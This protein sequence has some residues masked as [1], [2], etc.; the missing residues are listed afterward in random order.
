MIETNQNNMLGFGCMRLPTRDGVPMSENID[1]EEFAKMANYFMEAGFTYF[2]TSM[3]Y[4]QGKSENAVKEA[5]VERHPRDSFQVATKFP[6][7]SVKTEDQ[8]DEFF[9]QQLKNLGVDYV[10][11]YLL[12]IL[13]T[14]Y[15]DGFDMKGG[16]VESC[17]L[18]E[19]LKKFKEQ[20]QARH[21]GFSFHDSAD[22]LDKLLTEHPFVEFVQIV[23]NYYDWDSYLIQ[24]KENYEV[25]RKHG[26]AIIAME[27]V[28]GGMLSNVPKE[29]L[30][31]MHKFDK[32]ATPS[33]W[34][35]R[36]AASQPGVFKVLSGMSN[37]QQVKDNVSYMKDFKPLTEEETE[38]L[39]E[40]ARIMR[41][42]GPLKEYD[43]SKYESLTYHG[44]PVSAILQ[45]Y[46]S[47][48]S[49][50]TPSFGADNNYIR[51]E[52]IKNGV[53]DLHAALPDE[54]VIFE[55]KDITPTVKEAWDY[56]IKT[57]F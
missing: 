56:L 9:A 7:F 43:Y 46:N 13:M 5:V 14:Q 18:F 17:H 48:A 37:M 42:A 35:V 33:S 36:F 45:T 24:S 29:A 41:K 51:Q 55:G 12:H 54:T 25:L 38:M 26:K 27:P 28:K 49:S 32:D 31:L 50:P 21:V 2:D 53:S 34:A 11:F 47:I 16:V 1:I 15:I 23:I 39:F 52:L 19:H 20:G 3:A 22:V 40:V 30:E 10:D 57:A 4:H 8:V 44:I 6:T